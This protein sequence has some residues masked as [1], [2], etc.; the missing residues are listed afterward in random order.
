MINNYNVGEAVWTVYD[1]RFGCL[2]FPVRDEILKF[3]EKTNS[4]LLKKLKDETLMQWANG[5][6]GNLVS[7]KFLFETK[8]EA[9][10][11]ILATKT[12]EEKKLKEK[13]KKLQEKIRI[14]EAEQ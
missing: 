9:C 1:P 14:L 5:W 7:I 10:A 12:A 13:L 3:S 4:V 8:K 2:D 6:Y 11:F